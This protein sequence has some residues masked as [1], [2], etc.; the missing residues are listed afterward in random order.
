M[1]HKY[2]SQV[3]IIHVLCDNGVL[4]PPD[5]SNSDPDIEAAVR[6]RRNMSSTPIQKEVVTVH[7]SPFPKAAAAD[8]GHN[9]SS[10][11][12]EKE[13]ITIYGPSPGPPSLQNETF[14]SNNK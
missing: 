4:S 14:I 7:D 10:A 13:V 2:T 9:M 1:N 8:S 5:I 11:P 3:C 6:S 12:I